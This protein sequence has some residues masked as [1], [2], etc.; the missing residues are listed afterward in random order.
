[1]NNYFTTFKINDHIYQIKEKMGV[2]MTLIIGYNKA[3]LIDTGYG[4]Y[5][6]KE[7]IYNN[8]TKLPL[9]VVASH[10]HMD[11]TGGN[12]LFDKVYIHPDDIELC[13]KH[14]SKKWRERDIINATNLNLI[15]DNFDR[16]SFIEKR[17]GTLIPIE[18][19]QNFDLGGI[20][21]GIVPMEG[22]TKGS[23]GLYIKEDKYLVVADATCPFVWLFLEEST[24]VSTYIKMLERVL[25]IEF[26]DVLLGHGKGELVKRK[27]VLE[28]LDV[29]KTIDL[30]KAVKVSF[31]NFDNSNSYCYTEG[32]MYNQDHCG[33]VF[34]P[35][36]M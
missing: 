24:P 2:L 5:N 18:L 6:I 16:T 3:M 17:E 7:Y 29:A 1:M 19:N 4:L 27:R 35:D 31:N 9:I 8:I 14:N 33:I 36:K 11:H 22:H 28:F 20:N 26:T 32:V 30:K 21:I 13:I 34:D 10:G 23:I 12:Y 15:D 25:K